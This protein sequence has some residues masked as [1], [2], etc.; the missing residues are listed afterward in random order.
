[1]RKVDRTIEGFKKYFKDNAVKYGI[2]MA[3]LFGSYALG[4]EKKE[5]DIDIAVKLTE[6]IES[7]RDITFGVITDLSYDLSRISGREV[8]IIFIDKE[9][10]K[11]ML[12]YN[13]IIHGIPLFISDKEKYISLAIR[14]LNE[15]EDFR[16]FGLRWQLEMAEKKLSEVT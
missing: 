4:F 13:A 5:S 6:A 12:F 10:S 9:F 1:M 16:I 8:S 11:P 14:A 7:D 3:F 15:M 2:E